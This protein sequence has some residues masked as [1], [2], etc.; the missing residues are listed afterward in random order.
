MSYLPKIEPQYYAQLLA[1][2]NPQKR[3][4]KLWKPREIRRLFC[5]QKIVFVLK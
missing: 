5:L 2:E 4:G 1:A 3:H